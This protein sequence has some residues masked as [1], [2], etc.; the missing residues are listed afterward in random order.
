MEPALRVQ[1]GYSL[2]E[3]YHPVLTVLAL[4]VKLARAQEAYVTHAL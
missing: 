1:L 2:M 4:I 3:E